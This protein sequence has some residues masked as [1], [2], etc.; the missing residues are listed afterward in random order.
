MADQNREWALQINVAGEQFFKPGTIDVVPDGGYEVMIKDNW[1]EPGKPGEDGKAKGDNIVFELEITAGPEKGKKLRRYK[2][3]AEG[4]PGSV[5]RKEWKNLL[6]T[7]VK[8]PAALEQ[9]VKTIKADFLRGKSTFVQVQNPPEGAKTEAGKKQYANVNFIT[10]DM[11][12]EL[13]ATAKAAPKGA[14]PGNGATSGAEFEVTG[15]GKTPQPPA[16]GSDALE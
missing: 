3:A 5:G 9:G 7:I 14:K 8:D 11:F 2:S 15:G 10:K 4:E 12:A 1:R 16:E 6:S 13:K